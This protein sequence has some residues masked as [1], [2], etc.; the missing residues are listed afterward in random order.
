M[1]IALVLPTSVVEQYLL[2]F[3]NLLPYLWLNQEKGVNL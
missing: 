3:I 1:F 2:D